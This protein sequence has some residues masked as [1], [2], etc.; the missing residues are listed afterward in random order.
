MRIKSLRVSNFRNVEAAR[1]V[2]FS[3][4]NILVGAN[5]QGKTNILEAIYLMGSGGSFR[6]RR[7]EEMVEDGKTEATVSGVLCLDSGICS[8]VDVA[9][10]RDSGGSSKLILVDDKRVTAGELAG[11]FPMVLFSP[12]EVDLVRTMAVRRRRIMDGLGVKVDAGYRS[13]LTDYVR[14]WRH[15]NQ[16]LLAIKQHR[17]DTDELDAWD[18]QMA[19]VGARLTAARR[20]LILELNKVSQGKYATFGKLKEGVVLQIKYLPNIQAERKADYLEI[21]KSARAI[22]IARTH[23]T[24]GIHRDDL[25][26]WLGGEDALE[27]AS[28][29][30]FRSIVLAI[31]L[32]EGA[33]LKDRLGEAPIYLLDDVMSELDDVRQAALYEELRGAQLVITT[34]HDG[35][36]SLPEGAQRWVVKNGELDYREIDL[37]T[38]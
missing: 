28:R 9:L 29:G 33:I 24:R 2:D 35:A 15:R 19:E 7:D 21:L 8:Q 31:K 4:V 23:T 11:K 10:R 30:E 17:A 27:R 34:T 38:G 20:D 5:G 37:V 1:L 16:L 32:A 26:M 22:D 18:E 14:I 13:D 12:E 3:N 6:A 36:E 25:G